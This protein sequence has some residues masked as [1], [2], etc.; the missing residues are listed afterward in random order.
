[1]T[2]SKLSGLEGMPIPLNIARQWV[3]K[4]KQATPCDEAC[5]YFGEN[6]ILRILAANNCVG[7]R[8]YAGLDDK[9][10]WQLLLV[11][12]DENGNN[13]IPLEGMFSSDEEYIIAA[14]NPTTYA[15]RDYRP[16]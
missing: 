15:H 12:V 4:F 5:Y 13:L 14:P 2:T 11:G 10:Q 7:I 6:I 1:M 9:D 16:L 3:L 8:A